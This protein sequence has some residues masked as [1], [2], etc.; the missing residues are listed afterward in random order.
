MAASLTFSECLAV[1][2]NILTERSAK[3]RGLNMSNGSISHRARCAG[4]SK[5][6]SCGIGNGISC[7]FCRRPTLLERRGRR[8]GRPHRTGHN[9]D[10]VGRLRFGAA[11]EWLLVEAKANVEE[12]LSGCQAAD[13][14]SVAL[15]GETLNATKA[16][17]GVTASCDWMRPYYQFC[18]RLA[19]FHVL[20]RA[21]TPAQLLYVYFCNDV[22]DQRRTCPTSQDGWRAELAKQDHHLGL[23]VNHPLHDR[24]HKLFLDVKC[25]E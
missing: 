17:L 1:I 2:A 19:A 23:A 3:R 16:A 8:L 9:W 20:N 14:R 22:G 15:I 13:A 24:V 21:G 11:H 5:E 10:A 7:N 12:I 6:T 25:I 18:N 4:T